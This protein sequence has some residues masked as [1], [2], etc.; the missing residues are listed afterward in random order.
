[1]R[2][3]LTIVF[4]I[5]SMPFL[6]AQEE[7]NI[8]IIEVQGYSDRAVMPD[9]AVFTISLEE[10]FMKVDDA[11]NA[12]NRK[13][14]RLAKEIKSNRVKGYRLIAD[15]YSV[16]LNRIYRKGQARDS[17]YVARQTLKI[18]T[19]S[20]NKDLQT[21]VESIQNAGDMSF[22]LHFR[23]SENTRKSL[24]NT[25]LAEAL[26]DAQEKGR[27]IANTLALRTLSIHRVKI[28]EGYQSSPRMMKA[29]YALDNSDV[30][31]NPNDQKISKKVLVKFTY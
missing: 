6:L 19:N 29:E 14:E 12:L 13:S 24:D 22:N 16:D 5:G 21:I 1:M 7:S 3:L 28:L 25:L 2:H 30:L 8:P 23:I 11:V 15:N 9:E 10:K 31:I 4:F 27:L 26:R 18:I 20:K 17:G